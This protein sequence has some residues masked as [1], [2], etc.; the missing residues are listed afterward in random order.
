MKSI[1]LH[2]LYSTILKIHFN[3]CIRC[4]IEGPA[5]PSINTLYHEINTLF[6]SPCD[7][8]PR[9][10]TL[11]S[12]NKLKLIIIGCCVFQACFDERS[13]NLSQ[14]RRKTIGYD[15]L[16]VIN[17]STGSFHA[18]NHVDCEMWWGHIVLRDF[19]HT[20]GNISTL[21]F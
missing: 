1:Q 17:T 21:L 5:G 4:R 6:I 15:W 8:V 14:P 12:P 13:T 3:E 16:A 2:N 20:R 11:N 19:I 10:T 9:F 7:E 18:Y